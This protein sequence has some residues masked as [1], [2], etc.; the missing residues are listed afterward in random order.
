MRQPFRRAMAVVFVCLAVA[1]P[2]A[3]CES[4]TPANDPGKPVS[5]AELKRLGCC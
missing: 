2:L 3:G 1:V 4:D 5:S